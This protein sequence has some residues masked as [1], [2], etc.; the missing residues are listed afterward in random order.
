M[1]INSVANDLLTYTARHGWKVVTTEIAERYVAAAAGEL[2]EP[3]V[4]EVSLKRNSTRLYRVFSSIHGQRYR[5]KAAELA[6]YVAAALVDLGR[7]QNGAGDLVA[8]GLR[9]CAEAH[10]AAL[11][12]A[13][14]EVLVREVLEAIESLAAYLPLGGPNVQIVR[15]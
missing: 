13:P 2:L 4:D 7:Q 15:V 5:K 9:E 8:T 14:A 12:N 10:T 3:V 6:S 1:D 11:M